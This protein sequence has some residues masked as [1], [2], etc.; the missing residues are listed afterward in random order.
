MATLKENMEAIKLE[1]DTKILPE[2]LRAGIT[3]F[4]VEGILQEGSTDIPVKLFK[5]EEEMQADTSAKQDDLAIVC[6]STV[7]P[8]EL[9]DITT[10]LVLPKTVVLTEE[11]K[12]LV[13][14][15]TMTIRL[16][17]VDTS[18]GIANS[19]GKI[20]PTRFYL[21]WRKADNTYTSEYYSSTDG[22]TYTRTT[23]T[24]VD[25]LVLDLG[26]EITPYGS[27]V[28]PDLTS[29]FIFGEIFIFYGMYKYSADDNS[30]KP[31]FNTFDATATSSDMFEGVTAYASGEKIVGNVKLIEYNHYT[32]Y[33]GYHIDT[34]T[35]SG[36]GEHRITFYVKYGDITCFKGTLNTGI[37]L[38]YSELAD[39][40]GLTADKIKKG[41][42]ILDIEGTSDSGESVEGAKIFS[43][44]EEMQADETAKEGDLAII[45]KDETQNMNADSK[46]QV[47]NFPATVVLPSVI[48]RSFNCTFRSE[49][50]NTDMSV[51]LSATRFRI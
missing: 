34:D 40:I 37:R 25:D 5:T 35:D 19:A 22:I 14:S 26:Y 43:S 49:S 51:N 3:A 33:Q 7:K 39:V 12:T 16:K 41:E 11:E 20:E 8:F 45:Y 32:D 4:G 18:L 38:Y 9:T 29:K 44:I 10:K 15:S 6:G 47:I 23:N 13:S 24:D 46:A 28:Y 1:K 48:S 2:N 42:T 17:A 31:L 27:S 50:Y 21:T 30:Y 36:S